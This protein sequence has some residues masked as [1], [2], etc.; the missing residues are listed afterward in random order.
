[1]VAFLDY[2]NLFDSFEPNLF[3]KFLLKMGIDPALVQLF[4]D[5]NVNA[6][7]RIRIG[8]VYSEEFDTFNALGQ[9]DPFTLL[10]ALLYVSVQFYA[11]DTICPGL[12]KS[13]VV[14]DRTI[15]ANKELILRAILWIQ[16]YD[17]KAG[18]LTNTVKLLIMATTAES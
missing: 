15:R 4:L 10:G 1:M 17:K 3:A 8:G 14:D 16:K 7:R 9:G 5:S 2:Q 12:M 11:L 6:R 13:A 18:H